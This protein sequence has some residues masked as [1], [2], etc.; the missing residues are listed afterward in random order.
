MQEKKAHSNDMLDQYSSFTHSAIG[1]LWDGSDKPST[2]S[3]PYTSLESL[4]Y[5]QE[6]VNA[7]DAGAL[8]LASKM[9]EENLQ[10]TSESAFLSLT[11]I[12][13]SDPELSV[14][15]YQ[16]HQVTT[17]TLAS[18]AKFI[19]FHAQ[20]GQFNNVMLSIRMTITQTSCSF[21]N[22]EVLVHVND[23]VK[24]S[25][26]ELDIDLFATVQDIVSSVYEDLGFYVQRIEESL[27]E[28][29]DDGTS[30][31]ISWYCPD[32]YANRNDIHDIEQIR[33]YKDGVPVDD[34][35]A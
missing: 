3:L 28:Y 1:V 22:N 26:E 15:R 7:K 29:S 5:G 33:A 8:A 17:K 34:I 14:K 19:T 11:G 20:A 18:I 23:Y 9:L 2:A 13:L 12:D 32:V 31:R 6:P 35:T 4:T 27:S 25:L 21:F 10:D 16:F 24:A 30:I